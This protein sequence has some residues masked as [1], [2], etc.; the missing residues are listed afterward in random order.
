MYSLQD[1]LFTI[2]ISMRARRD[3]IC[4]QRA[5]FISKRNTRQYNICA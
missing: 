2:Y 3:W 4:F 5:R 1:F